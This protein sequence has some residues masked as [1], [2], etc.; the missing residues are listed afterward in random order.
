MSIE[1]I[2]S[3]VTVLSADGGFLAEFAGAHGTA[4]RDL[5]P[6]EVSSDTVQPA[7]IFLIDILRSAGTESLPADLSIVGVRNSVV[8]NDEYKQRGFDKYLSLFKTV[9]SL[10]ESKGIDQITYGDFVSEIDRARGNGRISGGQEKLLKSPSN[11]K[12]FV[13]F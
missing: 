12:K 7:G 6:P 9:Y 2:S 8:I 1:N 11:N 5:Q 3:R 13:S 4:I 10:F